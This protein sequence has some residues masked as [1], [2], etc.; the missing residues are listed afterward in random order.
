MYSLYS[1]RCVLELTRSAV[2]I[3]STVLQ[4]P[5]HLTEES[6]Q[7]GKKKIE[8]QFKN[9]YKEMIK[10]HNPYISLCSSYLHRKIQS[11]K[12]QKGKKKDLFKNNKNTTPV[13][14]FPTFLHAV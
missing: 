14:T 11:K 12:K 4:K 3:S 13:F 2:S 1:M 8:M 10:H 6:N 5:S 7:K 9:I